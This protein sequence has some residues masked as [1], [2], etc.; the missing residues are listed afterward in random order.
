MW[1]PTSMAIKLSFSTF[2]RAV[3]RPARCAACRL[4]AQ[5]FRR[6]HATNTG[7]TKPQPVNDSFPEST[8]FEDRCPQLSSSSNEFCN[9]LL[10]CRSRNC[11]HD[12]S[13]N[14]A[15]RA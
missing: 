8:T 13:R 9:E 1:R 6:L 5:L 3:A 10:A 4:V 11:K 14:D 15:E 7:A 2:L 12:Q